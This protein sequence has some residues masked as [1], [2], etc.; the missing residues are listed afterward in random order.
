MIYV[1]L[2]KLKGDIW[3]NQGFSDATEVNNLPLNNS[4][5]TRNVDLVPGSGDPLEL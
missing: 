3:T 5:D 2:I 1:I 4:G